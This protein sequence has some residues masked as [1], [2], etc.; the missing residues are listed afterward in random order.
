[1][2]EFICSY[3]FRVSIDTYPTP[4]INRRGTVYLGKLKFDLSFRSYDDL[5]KQ[6]ETNEKFYQ[7]LRYCDYAIKYKD[8]SFVELLPKDLRIYS[9]REYTYYYCIVMLEIFKTSIKFRSSI[10]FNWYNKL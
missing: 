4:I 8:G 7:T 3:I 2:S 1:M 9:T 5:E 6:I 10:E